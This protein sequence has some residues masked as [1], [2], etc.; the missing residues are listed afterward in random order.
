MKKICIKN[1]SISVWKKEVII[2]IVYILFYNDEDDYDDDGG[3]EVLLL[4]T[5]FIHMKY[6]IGSGL[7]I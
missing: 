2:I 4:C 7:H 5:K 6:S 3:I 1:L